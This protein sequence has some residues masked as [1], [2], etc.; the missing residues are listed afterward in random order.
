MQ[1]P[2]DS[3]REIG[4]ALSIG[5][6]YQSK[7]DSEHRLTIKLTNDLDSSY[8]KIQQLV[9]DL[10]EKPKEVTKT[11]WGMVGLFSTL[12]AVL[13]SAIYLTIYLLITK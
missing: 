1:I 3:A 7:Y 8:N 4:K 6:K 11:N 10:N 13:T 2:C 5:L 9:R 12:T